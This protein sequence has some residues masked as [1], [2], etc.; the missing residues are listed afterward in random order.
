M[1]F[2]EERHQLVE[3]LFPREQGGSLQ[4]DGIVAC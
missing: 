2:L 4:R 1:K 3:L